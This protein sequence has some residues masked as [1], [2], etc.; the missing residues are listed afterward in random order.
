MA[1]T[2]SNDSSTPTP[3]LGSPALPGATWSEF[4][5]RWET[6]HRQISDAQAIV[7]T[8]RAAIVASEKQDM[9]FDLHS[10]VLVDGAIVTSLASA[11]FMLHDALKGADKL[12]ALALSRRASA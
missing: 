6:M 1:R 11:I 7:G 3:Q 5:G 12:R 10:E 4:S 8:C 9:T 2:D